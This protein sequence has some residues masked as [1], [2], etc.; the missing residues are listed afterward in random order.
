MFAFV[1]FLFMFVFVFTCMHSSLQKQ[2][3]VDP[4]D[5]M[6][7]STGVPLAV[8]NVMQLERLVASQKQ[9]IGQLQG[10]SDNIVNRTRS[11]LAEREDDA[12]TRDG[13][14]QELE[15]HRD[16]VRKET[17]AIV[18]RGL[19]L[20]NPRPPDQTTA[21]ASDSVVGEDENVTCVEARR[22]KAS[23]GSTFHGFRDSV[24][25]AFAGCIPMLVSWHD[26]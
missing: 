5:G 11:H 16:I 17:E 24:P 7:E 20:C 22:W 25:R 18:S 3:A 1:T 9:V 19:R 21:A 10:L 15:K 13:L 12:L 23:W 14:R 2:V 26:V 4:S 8:Q 6:V